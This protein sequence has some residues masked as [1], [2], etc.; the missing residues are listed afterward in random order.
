MS[1]P[2]VKVKFVKMTDTRF[3]CC[4][5]MQI[6]CECYG[7]SLPEIIVLWP[8]YKYCMYCGSKLR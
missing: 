6:E 4:K 8:K 3:Y 5:D 7:Y 2:N 1:C